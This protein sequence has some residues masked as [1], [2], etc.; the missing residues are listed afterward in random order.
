MTPLD[1]V[2][3]SGAFTL[4]GTILAWVLARRD[5]KDQRAH[6]V[7]SPAPP[8]TQEVWTRLDRVE[9]VLGS[10]VVLLGEVADQW[11]GDHP[12]VLSKRHV[13]IVTEAGYMPS[14]WEPLVEDR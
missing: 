12:P 9:R 8:S 6:D 3:I 5:K 13:A 1:V 10:S 14:E 4:V 2:L 11:Q 7:R